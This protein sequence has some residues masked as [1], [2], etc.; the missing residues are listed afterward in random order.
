MHEQADAGDDEQ[1]ALGKRV[2]DHPDVDIQVGLA[3]QRDPLEGSR[4]RN[5]APVAT[6]MLMRKQ[7]EAEPTE[8]KMAMSG[9]RWRSKQDRNGG[10]QRQEEKKPGDVHSVESLELERGEVLNLGGPFQAIERDDQRQADGNFRRGDGDDEEDEDLAVE[11]A[12]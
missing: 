1:H 10:D 4:Y 6:K 3:R 5:A 8:A 7:S 11:M 2:E 12:D 9:L